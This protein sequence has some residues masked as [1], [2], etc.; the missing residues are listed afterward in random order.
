MK[1]RKALA[2]IPRKYCIP[3]KNTSEKKTKPTCSSASYSFFFGS[4]QTQLWGHF[5]DRNCY[6]DSEC[7][8]EKED[9]GQMQK[10]INSL[11]K[12]AV[13]IGSEQEKCIN[14]Q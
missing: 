9:P 12:F 6:P 10:E 13:L 5:E 3:G 8:R 11:G 1:D 14:L 2:I 7:R 4:F